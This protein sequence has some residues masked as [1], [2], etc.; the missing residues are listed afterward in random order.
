[1]HPR[2]LGWSNPTWLPGDSCDIRHGCGTI[3]FPALDFHFHGARLRT[4][5]DYKVLIKLMDDA[6]VGVICNMDGG[7]GLVVSQPGVLECLK[8]P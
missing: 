3:K 8:E 5:E 7:L 4:A 6:G 1:M 2:G